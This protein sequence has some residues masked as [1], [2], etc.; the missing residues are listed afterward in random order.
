MAA[1]DG[2]D[3]RVMQVIVRNNVPAQLSVPVG[4]FAILIRRMFD[5]L[6]VKDDK[7]LLL[8]LGSFT[9]G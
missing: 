8:M 1:G 7:A 9:T 6:K 4:C 2:K 3:A 5:V